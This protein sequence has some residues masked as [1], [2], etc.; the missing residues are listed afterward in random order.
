MRAHL[1]DGQYGGVV[2]L[3]TDQAEVAGNE[4]AHQQDLLQTLE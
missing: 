2:V 3:E 4:A 1:V